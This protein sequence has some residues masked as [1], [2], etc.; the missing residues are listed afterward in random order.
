MSTDR[1]R[2]FPA[3]S[4][5]AERGPFD[6]RGRGEGALPLHGV[7]WL[8]MAHVARQASSLP[9]TRRAMCIAV[10]VAALSLAVLSSACSQ[11]QISE[12]PA[13]VRSAEHGD[14]VAQQAALGLRYATGD[15]MPQD[16]GEAVR[17]YRLAAD[18]GQR[19]STGQPRRQLRQRP[20]GVP[21]DDGEAVRWFRLAAEQGDA[22]A[23][24]NL[25]ISYAKGL[26]VPE[27]ESEAVRWY[28][29][30]ADQG[31]ASAQANLG[32]RYATGRGVPQDDGEA[33]RWFRLAAD[34]GN[35]R[36]QTRPR[37]Q[38]RHRRRRAAGRR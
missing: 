32:G 27:D 30:A 17:W 9:M 1:S 23:Q 13:L 15:G 28:R 4:E 18:Q 11:E 7:L 37:P 21:Q 25:G 5:R 29:L 33:V 16:D 19:Q 6:A 26:G 3:R 20:D 2:D 14:A 35:A 31:D 36:A 34:Q 10:T 22:R 8:S 12:Q 24:D 38:V